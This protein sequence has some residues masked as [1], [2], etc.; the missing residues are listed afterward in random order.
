MEDKAMT[1]PRMGLELYS[2]RNELERDPLGTL[3]AVDLCRQAL[4]K[5][6]R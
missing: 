3:E 2:V 6:G 4:K 1:Q 5:M